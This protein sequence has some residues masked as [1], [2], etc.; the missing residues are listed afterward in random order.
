ML[1]NALQDICKDKQLDLPQFGPILGEVVLQENAGA[2][3]KTDLRA[4]PLQN[5]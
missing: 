5:A 3:Y 2:K 1:K 4:S